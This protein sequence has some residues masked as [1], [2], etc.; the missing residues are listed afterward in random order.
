MKHISPTPLLMVVADN[1]QAAPTD[2]A[3]K[4]YAKALEPKSLHIVR[5]G[6]FEVYAGN[7]LQE[8]LEAETDFLRQHLC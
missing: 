6:H 8:V 7:K 3:L 2:L 1:D 5:A 4:A